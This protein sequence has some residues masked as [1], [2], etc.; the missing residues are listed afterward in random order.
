ML[1]QIPLEHMDFGVADSTMTLDEKGTKIDVKILTI[2]DKSSGITVQAVFPAEAPPVEG[3]PPDF[4]PPAQDLANR[5]GSRPA[6]KL[7]VARAMPNV[8][9][10]GGMR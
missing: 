5:M 3:L 10:P 2:L 9:M 6:P 1:M 7:E 4:V 8:P